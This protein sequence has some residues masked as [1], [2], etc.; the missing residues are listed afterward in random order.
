MIM[1]GAVDG[2]RRLLVSLEYVG[3]NNF[4][5]LLSCF[6]KGVQTY[7][8]PSR[9]RS[10][11]GKEDVLIAGFM[12]ANREPERRSMICGKSTHNQRS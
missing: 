11:E 1:F 5:T 10:D 7:A 8:I 4:E 6:M 3:N 2:F 12:I 9:I